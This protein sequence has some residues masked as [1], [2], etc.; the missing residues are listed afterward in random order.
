VARV[1]WNI[2]GNMNESSGFIKAKIFLA[3]GVIP[4]IKEDLV[5]L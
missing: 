2:F 5:L 4:T 1:L 3:S